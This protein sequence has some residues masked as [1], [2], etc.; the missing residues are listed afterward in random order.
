MLYIAEDDL[1]LLTL[2]PPIP[3][4]KI[5]AWELAFLILTVFPYCQNKMRVYPCPGV[6]LNDRFQ[7]TLL[8]LPRKEALSGNFCACIL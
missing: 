6:E 8:T 3:D 1:V 5:I 4:A 7:E 2:Q